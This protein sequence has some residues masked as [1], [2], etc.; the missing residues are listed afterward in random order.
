MAPRQLSPEKDREREYLDLARSLLSTLPA[1]HAKASES[2]DFLIKTDHGLKGIEVTCFAWPKRDKHVEEH[3]S[4]PIRPRDLQKVLNRKAIRLAGY[5]VS[6]LSTWLIVV[7]DRRLP[8]CTGWVTPPLLVHT[9][10]SP[11]VGIALL[12]A[13]LAKCWE[14]AVQSPWP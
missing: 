7:M 4:Q 10:T 3:R 13:N 5:D 12:E 2:P 6:G 9:Y 8:R 14:L 11:F 1:G